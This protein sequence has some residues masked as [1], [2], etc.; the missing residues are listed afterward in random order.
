MMARNDPT[1][2][3]PVPDKEERKEQV[4]AC[5]CGGGGFGQQ[6]RV[7]GMEEHKEH[8]AEGWEGRRW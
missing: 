7:T 5:T 4:G 2:P 3:E 8:V 1:A 6:R